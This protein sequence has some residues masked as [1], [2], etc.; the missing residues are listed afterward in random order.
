MEVAAS[1]FYNICN[2]SSLYRL[3]AAFTILLCL[4]FGTDF[5]PEQKVFR[6]CFQVGQSRNGLAS[7]GVYE[8]NGENP[9]CIC[10]VWGRLRVCVVEFGKFSNQKTI[11][12][13]LAGCRNAPGYVVLLC[14]FYTIHKYFMNFDGKRRSRKVFSKIAARTKVSS[15]TTKVTS[16]QI[17]SSNMPEGQRWL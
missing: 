2:G 5:S 6:S 9:Y 11:S 8:R 12:L 10:F 13:P 15:G 14:F 1:Q 16:V 17:A 7:E 3:A 4:T